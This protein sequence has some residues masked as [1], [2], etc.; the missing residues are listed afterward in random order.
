MKKYSSTTIMAGTPSSHAK[1]YLPITRSFH[2]V[3]AIPGNTLLSVQITFK[4]RE[5][6]TLPPS[7]MG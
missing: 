2:Q 3:F 4:Y 5:K 1:K 6:A 7:D